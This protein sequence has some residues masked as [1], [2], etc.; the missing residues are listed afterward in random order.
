MHHRQL[1]ALKIA[2]SVV[3]VGIVVVGVVELYNSNMTATRDDS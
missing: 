1:V 3:D 2:P